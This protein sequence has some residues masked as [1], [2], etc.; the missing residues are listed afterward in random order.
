MDWELIFET[1][2]RAAFAG[3]ES[4]PVNGASGD[5]QRLFLATSDW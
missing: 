3:S 1:T 2:I 5:P 4:S